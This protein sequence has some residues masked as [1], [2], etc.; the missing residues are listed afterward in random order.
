ME[1][2]F[3]DGFKLTLWMYW[4]MPFQALNNFCDLINDLVVIKVLVT[5]DFK[6]LLE[7]FVLLSTSILL[8]FTFD[9]YI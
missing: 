5:H 2:I 1:Y 7:S 6:Q 3:L 8:N 4:K 9:S